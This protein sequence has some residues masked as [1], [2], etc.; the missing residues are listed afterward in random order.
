VRRDVRSF[1]AGD[2]AGVPEAP[3]GLVVA[4]PPYEQPTD[5]AEALEHVGRAE[6]RWLDGTALVVAKHFWKAP[7]PE[8]PGR[9]ELVRTRRFG[10]TALSVYRRNADT[11]AGGE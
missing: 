5:L 6:A 3:F 11:A 4:D 7:P 1:L 9:L 2:P 10:E 8:R